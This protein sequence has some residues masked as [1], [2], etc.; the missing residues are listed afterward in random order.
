MNKKTYIL[1]FLLLSY[2]VML[3]HA[4]IPHQHFENLSETEHHHEQGQPHHH[5]E[6]GDDDNDDSKLPL[7]HVHHSGSG[8]TEEY[9]AHSANNCFVKINKSSLLIP[10]LNK[11]I[12]NGT[13]APK[14]R[15]PDFLGL[16]VLSDQFQSSISLRGPPPAFIISKA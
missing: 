1:S 6:S 4:F 7:F 12:F 8:T 5:P 2:S 9:I 13:E 3:A 15:Q 11:I 10:I 14:L 16:L